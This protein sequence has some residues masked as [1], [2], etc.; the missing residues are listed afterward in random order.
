MTYSPTYDPRAASSN[1]GALQRRSAPRKPG[2]RMN[3]YYQPSIL[4]LARRGNVRAIAYWL[5]SVLVMQ[6]VHIQVQPGNKGRLKIMVNFPRH[7]SPNACLQAQRHLIRQ[8]CYRLWTLN[9]GPIRDLRIMARVAGTREIVWRQSARIATPANGQGVRRS[10]TARSANSLETERFRLLRSLLVNRLAIAGFVFCYWLLYL[11]STGSHTANQPSVAAPPAQEQVQ[12]SEGQA[13]QPSEKTEIAR[14]PRPEPQKVFTVPPQFQ[15]QVFYEATPPAGEKVVALTF[16][17][18]PWK[19]T[20]EQVL[21]ILKQNNIKATFYMVGQAVQ[22]NPEI[23]KKVADAGHAIGNHTWQHPMSNLDAATAAQELGNAARLIYEATGGVRTYLMRP[24]GGNLDGELANYAKQQGYQVSMWSAD[25]SDYYVSTPLIIDNILSNIKPGGVALMHDGGG[26]RKATV[27]ALP[28]IIASLRSQ[29]YQ[30][31]TIPELMEKQAEWAKSQ[32]AAGTQPTHP[33][34]SPEGP[35][36]DSGATGENPALAPTP[37]PPEAIAPPPNAIEPPPVSQPSLAPTD[38]APVD[39][40]PMDAPSMNP[41]PM[42]APPMDTAPMTAPPM[43]T[44][45]MTAPPMDTAPRNPAPVRQDF[46]RPL[47]GTAPTPP[48]PASTETQ[49]QPPGLNP[50]QHREGFPTNPPPTFEEHGAVPQAQEEFAAEEWY[51][52]EPMV[53]LNGVLPM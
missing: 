11:E 31:V 17:D 51:P 53:T 23:A 4:E 10:R 43:D 41:A 26:D 37:A 18:G 49:P 7:T 30:F 48:A 5:N 52:L 1:A 9:A 50:P 16:D 42:N 15:G 12:P 34:T 13:A 27:E 19:E 25:S 6:G 24:P 22:E 29:G 47:G 2:Q 44:A 39:T 33:L 20:T 32:P 21:D 40:A 35:L 14:T 3:P 8:I 28:Q 46:E 36:P 45:P 38:S